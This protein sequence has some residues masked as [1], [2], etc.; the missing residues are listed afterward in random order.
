MDFLL[1]WMVWPGD[2]SD[3]LDY[4]ACVSEE[5]YNFLTI[6]DQ[7]DDGC[8]EKDFD[9]DEFIDKHQDL[10]AKLENRVQGEVEEYDYENYSDD[11]EKPSIY[12][13]WPWE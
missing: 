1:L 10:I 13:R 11:E 8:L 2:S 3:D 6:L 7:Y 12:I 4:E 5:E 9:I